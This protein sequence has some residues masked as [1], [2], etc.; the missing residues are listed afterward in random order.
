MR[1]KYTILCVIFLFLMKNIFIKRNKKSK[2]FYIIHDTECTFY[3]CVH[4]EYISEIY[5]FLKLKQSIEYIKEIIDIDVVNFR[6]SLYCL[7]LFNNGINCTFCSD[8]NGDS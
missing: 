3:F 4:V 6:K 8:V 7:Y 2:S 5:F 1:K